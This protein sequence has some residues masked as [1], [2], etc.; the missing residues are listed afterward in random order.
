MTAAPGHYNPYLQELSERKR[1]L[2]CAPSERGFEGF[3]GV[4]RVR[5][6]L[7]LVRSKTRE[8]AIQQAGARPGWRQPCRF[9][10]AV[11][12]EG[13]VTADKDNS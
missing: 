6:F 10:S 12:R 4:L 5:D 13:G 11:R 8:E 9:R 7:V 2:P 1:V 3:E